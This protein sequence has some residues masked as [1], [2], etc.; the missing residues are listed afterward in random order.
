MCVQ[1]PSLPYRPSKGEEEGLN[2]A[3]LWTAE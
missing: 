1:E 2:D 3:G